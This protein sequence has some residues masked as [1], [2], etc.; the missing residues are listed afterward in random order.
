MY[1]I[2]LLL[3]VLKYT[4]KQRTL[5]TV[6]LENPVLLQSR[7]SL[8]TCAAKRTLYERASRLSLSQKN[9]RFV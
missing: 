4:N 5:L 8:R 7:Y 1:N 9:Y 2:V 6:L 3:G